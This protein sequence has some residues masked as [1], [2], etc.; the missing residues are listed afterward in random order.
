M[1]GQSV[2]AILIER[3]I[4]PDL[5]ELDIFTNYHRKY[6]I[7]SSGAPRFSYLDILEQRECLHCPNSCLRLRTIVSFVLWAGQSSIVIDKK[8]SAAVHSVQ[9]ID[10]VREEVNKDS[11]EQL[12]GLIVYFFSDFFFS[13]TYFKLES[14]RSVQNVISRA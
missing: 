6:F 8:L 3:K 7:C 5:L 9:S 4:S 12:S 11:Q 13:K 10:F 2:P 1:R 14:E